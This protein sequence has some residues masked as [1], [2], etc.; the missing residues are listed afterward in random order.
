MFYSKINRRK[1]Q[2]CL[3]KFKIQIFSLWSYK[4]MHELKIFQKYQKTTM[5][6][7]TIQRKT[8]IHFFK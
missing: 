6:I 3:N 2:E 5:R 7:T 8:Y 1:I 4:S